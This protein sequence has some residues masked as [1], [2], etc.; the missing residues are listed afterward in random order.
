LKLFAPINIGFILVHGYLSLDEY[1]HPILPGKYTY[2]LMTTSLLGIGIGMAVSVEIFAR[3][4]IKHIY[5]LNDGKTLSI[6]FHNAFI[7]K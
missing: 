3:K 4:F 5:L 1:F 7:V 6:E 2:L